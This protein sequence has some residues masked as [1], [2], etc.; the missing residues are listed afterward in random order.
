MMS[1][2]ES[3]VNAMTDE[4]A[5]EI[6][7]CLHDDLMRDIPGD[8]DFINTSLPFI[9]WEDEFD[10]GKIAELLHILM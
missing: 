1:G 5:T 9:V 8:P 4:Y 2:H 7:H 6:V 10:L 3:V